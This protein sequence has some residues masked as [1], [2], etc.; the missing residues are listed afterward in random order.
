V[1]IEVVQKIEEIKVNESDN[2]KKIMEEVGSLGNTI[3]EMRNDVMQSMESRIVEMKKLNDDA[4]RNNVK[5]N[6]MNQ[7]LEDLIENFNAKMIVADHKFNSL[8]ESLLAIHNKVQE[9]GLIVE[10]QYND[11]K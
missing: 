6:N 3:N 1:Q 10:N 8:K 9:F 11:L 5:I 4:E 7:L 2:K